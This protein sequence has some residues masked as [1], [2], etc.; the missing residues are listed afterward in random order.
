MANPNKQKGTAAE[1]AVVKYA[2]LNGFPLADRLTLSGQ[3]DRGDVLLTVGAIIEV[4]AGHA[5]KTASLGQIR[6]WLNETDRER[7]NAKASLA[8]LVKQRTGFGTARV[9]QWDA[10]F[11]RGS[12]ICNTIEDQ[13][14]MDFPLCMSLEHALTAIRRSGWGNPE[15]NE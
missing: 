12:D 5:A 10:W 7:S 14:I 1:S 3:Y 6:E 9:D 2:R 8:F 13:L 4:K 11:I 15:E